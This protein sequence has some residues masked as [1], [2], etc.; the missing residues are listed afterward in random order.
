MISGG[1]N[2]FAE[3]QLTISLQVEHSEKMKSCFVGL[4]CGFVG[5]YRL[6]MEENLLNIKAA[7]IHRQIVWLFNWFN[8]LIFHWN[9][10]VN[11]CPRGFLWRILRRRWCIWTP[12]GS[13]KRSSMYSVTPVRIRIQHTWPI[14]KESGGS[15]HKVVLPESKWRPVLSFTTFVEHLETWMLENSIVPAEVCCHFWTKKRGDKR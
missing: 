3:N 13:C 11:F 1:N 5:Q 6:H 9:K 12:L 4:L 10:T 14:A 7:I 15:T 8:S 2:H